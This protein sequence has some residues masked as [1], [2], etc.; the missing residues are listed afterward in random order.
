ML[1]PLEADILRIEFDRKDAAVRKSSDA[2]ASVA[3]L[4]YFETSR[5]GADVPAADLDP[6]TDAEWVCVA[7]GRCSGRSFG[8]MPSGFEELAGER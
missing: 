7:D 4:G 2:V 6:R 3:V 1:A 5:P 8:H